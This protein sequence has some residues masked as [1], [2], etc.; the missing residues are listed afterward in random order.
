[1]EGGRG[2]EAS[3]VGKTCLYNTVFTLRGR[4]IETSGFTVLVFIFSFYLLTLF[5]LLLL[6]RPPFL[7]VN[8]SA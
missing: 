2:Q 1:M 8:L 4:I 3:H 7:F 6:I 5:W